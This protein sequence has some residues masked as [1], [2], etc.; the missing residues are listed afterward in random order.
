MPNKNKSRNNSRKSTA[1]QKSQEPAPRVDPDDDW[2]NILIKKPVSRN[3]TPKNKGAVASTTPRPEFLEPLSPKPVTP[4]PPPPTPWETLGMTESDYHA[5]MDRVRRQMM[6]AMRENYINNLLADLE[7]P[8]FWL[9]RIEQLEKEREYFNKK[10]GWSAADMV[11]VDRIDEEI[12]ECED[13]LER[14]YAKEDRLE[15]EYD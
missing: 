7:H 8:S 5:M 12:Q 6:E 1:S 14:I 9:R 10:R 13:E 15:V 11:A 4:P 3:T 2:G